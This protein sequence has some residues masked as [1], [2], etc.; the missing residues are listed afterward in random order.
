VVRRLAHPAHWSDIWL[1]EGFATYLSWL[2]LKHHGE[3]VFLTGLMRSQYGYELNAPDYGT[4]LEYPDLPPA[5]ILP[6]CAA[7]SGPTAGSC[8]MLRS[9][10]PWA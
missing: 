6:S 5:Q 9:S 3:R 7:S 4:L 10:P 8:P 1:N 2:W